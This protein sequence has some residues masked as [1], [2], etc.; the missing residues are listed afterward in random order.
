[1]T[2]ATA[3]MIRQLAGDQFALIESQI[4]MAEGASL[5][6]IA[7]FLKSHA[8]HGGSL[9]TGYAREVYIGVFSD[10]NWLE[11]AKAITD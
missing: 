11:V 5:S 4:K 3:A 1:M 7:Q 2:K 6:E 10:I 9:L 8:M